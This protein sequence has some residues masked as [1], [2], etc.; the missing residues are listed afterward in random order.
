MVLTADQV[1]RA[2]WCTHIRFMQHAVIR[3]HCRQVCPMEL[4]MVLTTLAASNRHRMNNHLLQTHSVRSASLQPFQN[5]CCCVQMSANEYSVSSRV[6]CVQC[7]FG[8]HSVLSLCNQLSSTLLHRR[9]D[10]SITL[11]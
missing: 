6:K 4:P 11:A 1:I 9:G 10:A 5:Q 3:F 2:A 8:V 7:A